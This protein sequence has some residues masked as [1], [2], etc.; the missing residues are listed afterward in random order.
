MAYTC[1]DCGQ[2][3]ESAST[4]TIYD[5]QGVEDRLRLL[6][7]ECYEEWLYSLKG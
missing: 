7:P 4:I 5:E 6:C 2:E 3:S 1:Q